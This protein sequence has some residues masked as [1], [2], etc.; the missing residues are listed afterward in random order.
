MSSPLSE[1]MDQILDRFDEAWNSPTPPR[2][3]GFAPPADS[4]VYRTVMVELFII[5]MDYRLRRGEQLSLDEYRRRFPACADA[6]AAC[7]EEARAA[8]ALAA[9]H[10][11][12][13]NHPHL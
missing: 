4:P 11:K 7:L 12:A 13:N 10:D 8:A 1:S 3:E 6:V 2:I 5:D 9:S